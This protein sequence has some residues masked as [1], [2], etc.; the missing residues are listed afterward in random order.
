MNLKEFIKNLQLT[1]RKFPET[2]EYLVVRVTDTKKEFASLMILISA[3][4]VWYQRRIYFFHL[5]ECKKKDLLS[6][7]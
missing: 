1:T 7:I 5:I 3:Y 2:R 4:L 6:E